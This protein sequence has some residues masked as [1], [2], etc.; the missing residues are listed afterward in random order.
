MFCSLLNMKK[1]TCPHVFMF[2]FFSYFI[3]TI[4]SK[5]IY[6]KVGIE[7]KDIKGYGHIGGCLEGKVQTF[8]TLCQWKL[9]QSLVKNCQVWNVPDVTMMLIIFKLKIGFF[10][11]IIIWELLHLTE[12][13]CWNVNSF[14]TWANTFPQK[15]FQWMFS[16][17]IFYI[18]MNL[19]YPS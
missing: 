7:K 16:L 6:S 19:Y 10:Y 11:I 18:S 4:L 8:C 13:N 1:A 15:I 12:I 3:G 5:K 9:L 17:I 14:V 2:V